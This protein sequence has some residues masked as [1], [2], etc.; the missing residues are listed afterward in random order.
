V[1]TLR[2]R[3]VPLMLLLIAL[4]LGVF[5]LTYKPAAPG[6]GS[7]VA[8]VGGPFTMTN[9]LG[10]RVT[11]K[12]FLGRYMLLFF[13]YTFCPDVCPTE[14]QVMTA[15]LEQLGSKA[16]AITPVLVT[17]DPARDTVEVMK[18]YVSNFHPR[19]V[20]LTG[21]E[22]ELKNFTQAYKAYYKKVE[23]AKRPQDYLMDHAAL[24]YL[25]GPD[26][27][28]IRHFSYTTDADKLAAELE[29]TLAR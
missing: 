23:N 19:L 4:G 22:A 11:E 5:S 1:S 7:G 13:G 8:L 15:A 28:F 25:M 16:D 12:D 14:M 21:T 2:R 17:V 6:Q 18:S 24:I 9:H 20:G 26:G 27:N 3:I 29:A 10:Q